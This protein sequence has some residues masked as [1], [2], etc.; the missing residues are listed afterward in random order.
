M[1][2]EKLNGLAIISIERDLLRNLEYETLVKQ[3]IEKEER[4]IMS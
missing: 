2:Q 1:S 3:F 4:K